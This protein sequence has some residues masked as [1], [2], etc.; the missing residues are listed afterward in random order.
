MFNDIGPKFYPFHIKFVRLY[1]SKK[2]NSTD[3]FFITWDATE[4]L[5]I[6]L[7]SRKSQDFDENIYFFA[8]MI[9]DE[10]L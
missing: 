6:H 1:E 2:V 9:S 10:N 5:C 7:F 8:L 4:L 3:T